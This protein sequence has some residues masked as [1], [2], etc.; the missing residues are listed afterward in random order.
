MLAGTTRS[1]GGAARR[2]AAELRAGHC[3]EGRNQRRHG[4]QPA[5]VS[6]RA[7]RWRRG[8]V[9][10]GFQPARGSDLD[11]LLG[12]AGRRQRPNCARIGLTH[13]RRTLHEIIR[14]PYRE[15]L[16]DD[17]HGEGTNLRH[18]KAPPGPDVLVPKF[19]SIKEIHVVVAGGTAG[20]F[21]VAI[22]GWLDH[23]IRLTE[24]H[25]LCKAYSGS[26]SDRV[27]YSVR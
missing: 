24:P 1:A 13:V 23:R 25:A 22:L 12:A 19:P 21:S 8:S 2:D 17:D 26:G 20:R 27:R 15:L 6:A 14:R 5:G 18:G 3:G 11:P 4:R 7:D 9:R 10:S 16:P